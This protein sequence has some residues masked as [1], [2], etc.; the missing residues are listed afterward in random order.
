MAIPTRVPAGINLPSGRVTPP[1]GTRRGV[2]EAAGEE[3]RSP[4]LITAVWWF[5]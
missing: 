4:S 1:G 3:Y 5:C 2:R